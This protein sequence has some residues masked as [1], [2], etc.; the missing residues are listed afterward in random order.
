MSV[1]LFMLLYYLSLTAM[2][3]VLTSYQTKQKD[4]KEK[5]KTL[6]KNGILQYKNPNK[7]IQ[8]ILKRTTHLNDLWFKRVRG[9]KNESNS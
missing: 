4:A 8:Y 7:T 1:E 9:K 2:V 3:V 5:P 6:Y